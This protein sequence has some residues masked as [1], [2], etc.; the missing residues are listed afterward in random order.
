MSFKA[1]DWAYAQGGMTMAQ[2]AVLVALAFHF[3]SDEHCA[4]P[5]QKTIARE[6]SAARSTVQTAMQALEQ[7]LG[8]VVTEVRVD[9]NGRQTASLYYLPDF[10]PLSRPVTAELEFST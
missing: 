4:R 7:D 1:V 3:N 8:L 2:K 9:A 6:I 10:D 5:S